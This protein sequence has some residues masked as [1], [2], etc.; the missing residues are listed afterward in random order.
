[1]SRLNFDSEGK[2]IGIDGENVKKK[3]TFVKIKRHGFSRRNGGE[4]GEFEGEG[5]GLRRGEEKIWRKFENSG[6]SKYWSLHKNGA[7]LEPLKF[8]NGKTQEDVVREIVE[9]IKNGEKAIFLHGVCGTGKSAIA[10]NVARALGGKAAI[11]VPV[12]NLQ[13]QY[14]EDYM[15]KMY[16]VKPSGEELR[17]GMI[18]GRDNHDSLF[19][20]G[21]SCADSLLP[22]TI[23]IIEKNFQLLKEYYMDNPLIRHKEI[24]DVKKLR[25]ISIA[26]TNP[27]WSPIIPVEYEAPLSDAV[28]KR[29]LGLRGREFIFYHRKKG[30]SYYDQYQSYINADVIIFNSAKYKIEVALDRKPETEV[31][32]IDEADEFLDSFSNQI[33]I[34]LTRLFNSLKGIVSDDYD[35]VESIDKIKEL[36]SLEEK[37]KRVLGINEEQIFHINDTHMGKIFE[38]FLKNRNVESE[39]SLD[40]LSYANKGIEAAKQFSDFIDDTYL[41][42]RKYEENLI[43]NLVTTNLSKRLGEIIEKNRAF[44]F[45]SGTLHSGEVLKDVFGIKSYKI[46]E[47]ETA[48][49]GEVEILRTGKEFDCSYK[50]FKN[51]NANR[52]NYLKALSG[53]VQKAQKPMLVHVNAFEDLPS[54][55]ELFKYALNMM[56]KEKLLEL[57]DNDKTGR[58]I[59]LFKSKMSDSLYST[60]CSRGVDFPGDI[61]HSMIFTKYPNPNVRNTFWKILER[62]HSK[63]FWEFYKD[64]ACREFLQRI[65]RA[66]RFK[67]DHV[68]V[69]SPDSRVLDAVREL[70]LNKGRFKY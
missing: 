4:D 44:V 17:I 2:L 23:Q 56:S 16:L 54:N 13:R 38:L 67:E 28:K 40:E 18:T 15:K 26:P 8:S 22:D 46:V 12:K 37:N 34:N 21:V 65:F 31:D 14:E 53:C 25:R 52:E 47:A 11:V 42:Y 60:K 32:I 19:K 48:Y 63:Y 3:K 45:M 9:L 6:D 57:Q 49:P 55:E 36:I 30:C 33:E 7:R 61:C 64:K 1:M 58:A 5:E 50:N 27:Y 24:D 59:S 51:G 29:Y 20:L 66:L 39:I 62:T 70:Q 10:L 43:V 35:V 41:T 69:L 68:Y